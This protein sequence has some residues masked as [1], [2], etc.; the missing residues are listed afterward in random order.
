MDARRVEIA[1][2][3][4]RD[5]AIQ[6]IT[7]GFLSDPVCR[8]IWPEADAYLETMPKFVAAF[9]GKAFEAGSAYLA[10]GG[11]A[12]ALWLPPGH[13]P[14]GDTIDA[15]FAETAAPEVLD[16]LTSVFDQMAAYHP[17]EDT[18]WYLPL[19]AAD[20]GHIGKGLGA[21]ILKQ[22]LRRCDED[23][24]MAYL[25]SSNPRNMSLYE[26]HGFEAIGQIQSGSSPTI[27]PM[28]REARH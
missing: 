24:L 13:E 1:S 18:C 17:H 26:R 23:G 12:A 4:D 27:Y 5:T 8:W 11:R 3:A 9:G 22:A 28:I 16:D 21:A 15:L 2:V 6:T 20:P 14:D 19:I 7:L 10:E 25:E